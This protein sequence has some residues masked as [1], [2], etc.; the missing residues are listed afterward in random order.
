MLAR[1]CASKTVLRAD[2]WPFDVNRMDHVGNQAVVSPRR[3]YR[4]QG[5]DDFLFGSCDDCRQKGCHSACDNLSGKPNDGFRLE[6]VGVDIFAAVAIYLQIDQARCKPLVVLMLTG[7]DGLHDAIRHGQL[8][9][10]SIV[11]IASGKD[12]HI[13]RPSHLQAG[14]MT[15]D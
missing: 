7:L 15:L 5:R 10:R 2:V 6:D 12:L 8:D 1:M 14:R 3:G 13:H 4:A 11:R 9:R